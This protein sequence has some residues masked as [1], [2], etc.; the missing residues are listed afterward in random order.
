MGVGGRTLNAKKEHIWA[1]S[2]IAPS[3]KILSLS[4]NPAQWMQHSNRNA[5]ATFICAGWR[6]RKGIQRL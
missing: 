2:L 6:Q 1:Y 5:L 4:K 3:G